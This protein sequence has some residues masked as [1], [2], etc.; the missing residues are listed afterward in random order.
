MIIQYK[1]KKDCCAC[2]ACMNICPKNAITMKSDEEGFTFPNIN[3]DLCIRCKQCLKVCAFQNVPI[4]DKEP[5]SAYAAINK[6]DSILKASSSGGVFGALASLVLNKKGIVFGCDYN[7]N[8]EPVHIAIENCSD[9]KKLQGSKYV[10]SYIGT[11]Y[12]KAKR[13]LDS[14]RWVLYTGTPCQIAGLKAYLGK[15]YLNLIT[16]DIVCHGVPNATFFVDYIRYLERKLNGKIIDFKFRDKTK[17]WGRMGKVIY[18]KD[19]KICNEFIHPNIS[20]YYSYFLGGHICRDSCYDCK[21]AC[22][23]REGDFTMCD[24]WGIERAHP[25]IITEKGVSA[26]LINSNKG[27]GFLNDLTQHLSLTKSNLEIVRYENEQLNY[28]TPKSNSRESI[29][30]KWRDEGYKAVEDEF[31]SANKWNIRLTKLKIMIPQPIKDKIKTLIGR[32]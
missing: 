16:A 9:I 5:I 29:L 26:L 24:F 3:H 22:G 18:L 14:E 30:K 10:Q 8:M 1:E 11:T 17:G 19:G 20:S 23:N 2:A 28:P 13:Y 15:D 31:Y 32:K 6:N 4:I 25:E 12:T 21:Y 27:I 7:E